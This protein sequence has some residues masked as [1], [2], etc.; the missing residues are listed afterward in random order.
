MIAAEVSFSY[1]EHFFKPEENVKAGL[2]WE[3]RFSENGEAA[4]I[5]R[6]LS[7]EARFLKLLED[8]AWNSKETFDDCINDDTI[9]YVY[10]D[11]SDYAKV[12]LYQLCFEVLQHT[13]LQLRAAGWKVEI[14]KSFPIK[15]IHTPEE[16]YMDA[17]E[18]SGQKNDWFDIRLGVMIDGEHV[19][20]LPALIIFIQQMSKGKQW[21]EFELI[22][23]DTMVPLPTSDGRIILIPAKRIRNIAQHLL[24]EFGSQDLSKG[25]RISKW[26]TAFLEEF[27]NGEAAAKMRWMG[28]TDLMNFA[29]DIRKNYSVAPISAPIGLKCEL[30]NYQL[31]GLNW[32]QFL[33]CNRLHGVLADDMGLGKTVQ[34]LAHILVEKESGRLTLP[35]L[36]V[37]PT[38]LMPNWSSEAAR[39]APDLKVLVLQGDDRAANFPKMKEFDL[40]LTTYPLLMRDKEFLLLHQFHLLILDEAQMVKNNKTHAYQVLQQVQASQRLCLTGTPMENHLGEL[41][42]LFHLLLPGFL[43]DQKIF[44]ALYRRPIEKDGCPVRREALKKRIKPFILRRTKQEVAT[45]LPEKT[46]IVR[47]INFGAEQR[48]LYE[49]IRIKAQEELMRQIKNQGLERSQIAVLDALL[50]LRQVC[51]DPRLVK[52][53]NINPL[54][55]SAKLEYLIEMVI[56]MV[57]EGRKILIFSQFTS[58][59]ALIGSELESHSIIFT[60]L[61]GDTKD[62]A[63]PVE[64]FQKGEFPVMLISLKAGGVGLNLTA[65]D[66]VI[67]YDPWW[68]PS[69]ENQ[70]TDRAHRIG[71]K[72]SVFVYKLVVTGSL[73]EKILELQERKKNLIFSILDTGGQS[74]G[75]LTLEDLESIFQPLT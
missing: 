52:I 19:D 14:D 71:Q 49:A 70:A 39:F 10:G 74:S 13:I 9:D 47:K 41:W 3:R 68:N 51:C 59:L 56:Q 23:D 72:K 17:D 50:K 40:I 45:E 67:H 18:T 22:K 28:S 63:T 38:S 53:E 35:A 12:E 2:L 26:H 61:T 21:E 43:G 64:K 58:M 1:G 69:V 24:L 20:M 42:S 29:K 55:Q 46:E 7:E 37:A 16:W 48:D 54:M 66:T 62:R 8:L 36:I 30:R 31:Q 33:R 73:E 32:M 11:F 15:G 65:A 75:Q 27:A 5:E 4:R 60:L 57:E 44:Q 25:L 6:R 34:T